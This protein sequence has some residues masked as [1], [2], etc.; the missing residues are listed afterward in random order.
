VGEGF[1][2]KKTRGEDKQE[3]RALLQKITPPQTTRKSGGG[4]K[5]GAD[6]KFGENDGY[7][8]TTEDADILLGDGT[9]QTLHKPWKKDL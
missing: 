6:G 8:W 2:K 4:G 5:E 7:E 3:S 9:V 1:I